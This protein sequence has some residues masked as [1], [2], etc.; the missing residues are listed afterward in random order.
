LI[1]FDSLTE[2]NLVKIQ[3]SLT[4][5]KISLADLLSIKEYEAQRPIIRKTIMEHKKTRRVPLGPNA[6]LHFEDYMVM[7]YQVLELMRAENISSET[8]LQQEI[9]AY[10]PLIPDGSN[11]KVTLM[12]EYP[13]PEERKTRLSELIGIEET[14][15][16]KL[17]GHEPVYPVANEDLPRSTEEKTSAVHFLR[18]EFDEKAIKSAKKG[19]SWIILCNHGKYHHAQKI[20]NKEIVKSLLRDFT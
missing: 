13:N 17:D 11:L 6:T 7:R 4:M 19:A 18:F 1:S 15:S 14:I 16:I 8:E 20:E 5:K 2:F 12:L 3:A 10:N 9:E